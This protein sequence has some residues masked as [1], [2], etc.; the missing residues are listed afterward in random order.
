MLD[1]DSDSLAPQISRRLVTGRRE[2]GQ[3]DIGPSTQPRRDHLIDEIVANHHSR[4]TTPRPLRRLS[5]RRHLNF[6]AC[7]GRQPQHFI[8]EV[9]ICRDHKRPRTG[10]RGRTIS[11]GLGLQ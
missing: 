4:G 11:G 9:G 5:V 6:D 7:G 1:T 2:A 3:H 10:G 8:E